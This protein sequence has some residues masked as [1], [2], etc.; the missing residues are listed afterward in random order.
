MVLELFLLIAFVV[1]LG[2]LA[3]AFVNSI[4]GILLIVVTLLLGVIVPLVLSWRTHPL[5]ARSTLIAAAL[6]LIGG[7]VL[8]YAI[9]MAGQDIA[10]AGR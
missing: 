5:G 7:L 9:V 1:S 4:Y 10:V 6:V 8:R 2:G 3:P